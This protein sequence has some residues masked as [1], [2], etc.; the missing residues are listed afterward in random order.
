MNKTDKNHETVKM[1]ILIGRLLI[2][3]VVVSSC[4][5]LIGGILFMLKAGGS[6]PNYSLFKGEPLA[7]TS[8]GG[9]FHEVLSFSSRGIMQ[10][11]IL[12]LL[13]TP[14]MRVLLSVLIFI[15][16]RDKLYV[17]V[18]TIVLAVLIYSVFFGS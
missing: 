8:V 17:V 10:L 9:I 4:I 12:L 11:G 16:E 3:G 2:V 6:Q 15:R 18:T 1:E 14:I 5:V 13:A 7:L